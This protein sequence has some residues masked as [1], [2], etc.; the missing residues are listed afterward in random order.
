MKGDWNLPMTNASAD[1]TKLPEDMIRAA[2]TAALADAPL[3]AAPKSAEPSSRA[4]PPVQPTKA[5]AV[6]VEPT[7]GPAPRAA[8]A[9]PTA[10]LPAF[11][12]SLRSRAASLGRG[13]LR[14][15][16]AAAG[17]LLT[18]GL[19]YG[20]AHLGARASVDPAE[21]RWSEAAAGLKQTHGDVVR[22]AADMKSMRTAIDAIKGE[23]D[24]ARG[25]A[26]VKQVQ[27]NE[28]IEK[29]NADSAAKVA[30]L[31]EQL[32]RIE[33]IQRDPARIA[34]LV[35]RLDRI[36]KQTATVAEKVAAPTPPPKPSLVQA[37]PADTV[38]QT[39]SIGEA[40]P[41]A[42]LPEKPEPKVADARPPEVKTVEAKNAEARNSE[43]RT[44]EFDPRKTQLDTYVLR[45]FGDGAAL[46]EARNG[47]LSEVH[48]GQTVAGL[49]RIEAI[50]RRGRQW[51]V[52]T[53]KGF[54]G[55]HLP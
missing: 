35:E 33:K 12:G 50:E 29:A 17:M 21:Q 3:E 18:A 26:S 45:D 43:S 37:A 38:T 52:V 22:L 31:A 11:A 48:P 27:F 2:V 9:G 55:E 54:I 25:D 1:S 16:A 34:A 40:K 51:V 30:R 47:R 36:E 24:R 4:A 8:K 53:S 28:R 14:W 5:E 19:G 41:A 39:G 10:G 44:P 49:G 6:T 13:N 7:T 32:D 46:I 23:R 15:P 20:V 42:R